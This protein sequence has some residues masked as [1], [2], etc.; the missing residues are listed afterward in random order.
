MT[1]HPKDATQELF[2]TMAASDKICKHL[3]LPFQ[4]GSDRVLKRMNRRDDRAR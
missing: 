3:H 4:S 2:D 1:S